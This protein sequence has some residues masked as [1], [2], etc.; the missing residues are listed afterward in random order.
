MSPLGRTTGARI[1]TWMEVLRIRPYLGF[2]LLLGVG[3]RDSVVTYLFVGE[4]Q[5]RA[6]VDAAVVE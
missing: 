1:P 2:S 6:V 3:V 4:V 5:E